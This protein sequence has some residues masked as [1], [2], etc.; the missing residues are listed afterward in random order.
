MPPTRNDSEYEERRQQIIDGALDV[1]STKG[2]EKA[3]NADIAHAAG[4]RSAGLIYHYFNDKADLL[5]QVIEQRA[6]ILRL[7]SHTDDLFQLPPRDALTRFATTF[8]AAIDN[9]LAVR[10]I[11]VLLGEAVRH[12]SVANIYNHIGPMRGFAFLID[13]LEQ[14]MDAELMRR[15]DA[16]AA[17]RCFLG[18]LITFMF[19]REVFVLPDSTTL[20][21]AT[22]VTTTVDLFLRGMAAE[23]VTL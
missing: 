4:V 9:P 13:Y 22:M 10:L 3:T 16:G 1:F 11:R 5:R 20:S 17:A 19:T 14:Q 6:P 12:S 18:P 21:A 7:L 8:I 2:F 15:T 23:G